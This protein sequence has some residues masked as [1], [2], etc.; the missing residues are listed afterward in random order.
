MYKY[1]F[2]F[3]SFFS[4]TR[5]IAC[6]CGKQLFFVFFLLFQSIIFHVESHPTFP[7]FEQCIMLNSFPF[8]YQELAYL[9]L[10][11]FVM[12]LLPL[13]V[14]I[15]CYTSIVI[16]IF[17]RST[18]TNLGEYSYYRLSTCASKQTRKMIPFQRK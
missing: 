1:Q 8:K 13:A 2:K 15:F 14:I 9:Y 12:Y 10:G 7:W 16:E 6:F 3:Y 5:C 11:M 4:M 17:R 18:D